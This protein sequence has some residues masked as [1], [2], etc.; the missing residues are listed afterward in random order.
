MGIP[1]SLPK[2]EEEKRVGIPFFLIY[3]YEDSKNI[4]AACYFNYPQN[5]KWKHFFS[6]KQ[7]WVEVGTLWQCPPLK[8]SVTRIEI[9]LS[10]WRKILFD[11]EQIQISKLWIEIP[12]TVKDPK[13]NQ[14]V[15][16][17][18]VMTLWYFGV[19]LRSINVLSNF[20]FSIMLGFGFLFFK[21]ETKK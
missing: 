19:R 12:K 2:K 3:D 11:S 10:K 21:V 13:M 1:F 4:T 7:L 20:S 8:K 18:D 15:R 5:G 9:T 17:L 14:S 6:L 16:M